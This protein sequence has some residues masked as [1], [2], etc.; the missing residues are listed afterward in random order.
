VLGL[1]APSDQLAI[2]FNAFR[3]ARLVKGFAVGRTIFGTAA[4]AWLAGDIDD[5][6]LTLQVAQNYAQ[7]TQSW[8]SAMQS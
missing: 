4:A 6:Q 5:A 2:G 7:V 3:G 8:H 1:D